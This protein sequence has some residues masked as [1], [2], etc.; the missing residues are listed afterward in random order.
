MRAEERFFAGWVI[1]IVAFTGCGLLATRLFSFSGWGVTIAA[2]LA[3]A[4]SASG[5]RRGLNQAATEL[6][7]L[8]RRLATPLLSGDNPMLLVALL[9]PVWILIGR[10][11]YF[12]YQ[13][14][15]DGGI[16][17]GH[18]ATFSDW[19]AH[20]TYTASFAFAENTALNLPL[21]TG[22]NIGYHA[23]I[24]Y[25]A[26]L[27]I[28]A[29]ATLPGALQVSGAFTLFA[30]PGV[31]YS[32]GMRVFSRQ[33]TALLGTALF[34]FF[35]GWGFIDFFG[36]F[37]DRGFEVFDSLPRTYTRAPEPEN[38][39]WWLE[40]PIVGHFFPQRPTMI[41]FPIVLLVL[42]WLYTAWNDSV[43]AP[44]DAGHGLERYRPFLFCGILV[45]VIPFFNLFAFGTPLAFVGVW[46]ILT[47]FRKEWLYFLVP[48]TVLALPVVIF[49]QPPDSTLEFPYDWVA[50]VTNPAGVPEDLSLVTRLTDWIV[51]WARNLGLFLPLLAASQIVRNAVPKRVAIGLLPVWLF[52]IVPNVIKPHPWNGNNT[53]YFIFVLLIG[54]LPIASLLVHTMRKTPLAALAI[55]PVL[56][57]L[58]FSGVLDVIATNDQATS[59]WPL[60]AMDGAGVAVGEWARTTDPDSVFVIELGWAPGNASPHQHPVPALSGRDLVIGNDGWVFDLGIPDWNTRKDHSRIILEAGGRRCRLPPRRLDRLRSLNLTRLVGSQW[61]A[62]S[63]GA[64]VVA[65]IVI[66]LVLRLWELGERPLHHDESLDAWWSWLFRNG[67]YNEYDPV[68]HGP[69]RF[70]I[71]AGLFQIFGET[72]AV[73]RLFSALCGT[74]VVGLPWFLRRELGRVGTITAAIALTISPTMLYYSRFGREDAQMVFL[75]L[76]A[77]VLGLSYLRTPRISTATG[78]ALTLSCSFAIKESTYLFGLLLAVYLLVLLAAQFDAQN[79]VD[80]GLETDEK[81]NPAFVMAALVFASAAL[82]VAVVIGNA[83]GELFPLIALYMASMIG[84]VV[85]SALPRIRRRTTDN[86]EWPPLV[87]AIGAIGL[88]G[89]AIAIGV[90]VVTWVLFFTVWFKAPGDWH[91]GFTRAISYWDSQQEVNR[92]GQPWYY[93][94][95]ALPA[96]EWLFVILAFVGGWRA[97]RKPTMMTVLM[98]WFAVGSLI[99]YSYAGERMPW[100]IAHPLLP[101]LILAGLGALQLWE[102]RDQNFMPAVATVL[103]LGLLFT[104]GNS[105]RSSFPNGADGR[106]ILSQAGQATP[107]LTAA[108]ERLDN[109][110]QIAMRETGSPARLAIGTN[111]AW[112]YNWYLRNRP[113]VTWFTN[114]NG[115]PTDGSVDVIIVDNGTVD[116]ANFPDYRPTL[117]AMRSW[118]VPTYNDAG[119]VGWLK[120]IRNRTLWEQQPNLNFAGVTEVEETDAGS[121]FDKFRHIQDG[122]NHASESWVGFAGADDS[123]EIPDP[124]NEVDDG[125]DVVLGAQ[126]VLVHRVERL[127]RANRGD[128]P[129]GLRKRL[130]S[131]LVDRQLTVGEHWCQRWVLFEQLQRCG[132]RRHSFDRSHDHVCNVVRPQERVDVVLASRRV[133]VGDF[134]LAFIY[135]CAKQRSLL[136]LVPT[137]AQHRGKTRVDADATPPLVLAAADRF[138]NG[139]SATDIGLK[140]IDDGSIFARV[141]FVFVLERVLDAKSGESRLKPQ[142]SV[143]RWPERRV[144]PVRLPWSH[145]QH[146]I[147]ERGN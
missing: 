141:D 106:E 140:P 62:P 29:G 20:L 123:I 87:Q 124:L 116:L 100:L 82:V 48:A 79:R 121:F 43:D 6:A 31:M 1:G 51:F 7:D 19:Q 145:G 120:Y 38:G 81:L 80:L 129:S 69:L 142:V 85:V 74:A 39:S 68:Y 52:F 131:Y 119:P 4:L 2:V 36:D 56:F 45:G 71:T 83:S 63:T 49:L 59:P 18:L 65:L 75:T 89:W 132:V 66:A 128:G 5:W 125:R 70:Y 17:V 137:P 27:L 16:Q 24:N 103:V 57:T 104:T 138:D 115:P 139:G 8:R 35:G 117:F 10:L 46:W 12:A 111:N 22:N 72:E 135:L 143:E 23:G 21:A 15:P 134:P 67:N 102:H 44:T 96:Y 28:P 105:I 94:L 147:H 95:Y 3:I 122:T 136:T 118:W 64:I 73:A 133:E 26:A 107:H 110:D 60:T 30:F 58:T 97:L 77:M 61:R 40:N 92:G 25:F 130:F 13:T 88:K 55:V 127:P 11:F 112:P 54:A 108:L 9:V 41:G 99:L 91:T 101:I 53:H 113:D 50:H 114:E 84:L 144:D 90:F 98:V 93:Y 47:R 42:A 146:R 14:A 76:L 78:L 34:M 37:S 109:I 86:F 33:A 32:V 126:P